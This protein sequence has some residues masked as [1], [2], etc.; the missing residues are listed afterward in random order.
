MQML[1]TLPGIQQSSHKREVYYYYYY[2]I[3]KQ[4]SHLCQ[5]FDQKLELSH[6][7]GELIRW[8]PTLESPPDLLRVYLTLFWT[9]DS[10]D[11][12]TL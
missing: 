12:M 8:S 2:L 11:P 9:I 10:I 6:V 5:V 4:E 7:T 1:G 3:N